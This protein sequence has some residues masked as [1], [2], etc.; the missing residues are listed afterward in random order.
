VF[1]KRYIE[2]E[3]R[4][5]GGT[6][7]VRALSQ[8]VLDEGRLRGEIDR[9]FNEIKRV[10]DLLTEFR[11]SPFDQINQM[12][13]VS[14][15]KVPAEIVELVKL[16]F[17][18]SEATSGKFDIS[19]ATLSNLWKAAIKQKVAPAKDEIL[20][21]KSLVDWRKIELDERE[22]TIYLPHKDMRMSLGGIGKGYA[23]DQAFMLLRDRG[24]E[25]FYLNGAGDIRVHSRN[26]AK[27]SWHIG[28]RNP[29]SEDLSKMIGSL[30]LTNEAVATSGDYIR[31]YDF[32][33]LT[34]HHIIDIQSGNSTNEIVSSTVIANTVLHADVLATSMVLLGVKCGLDMVNSRGLMAFVVDQSGKVHLSKSFVSMM[35]NER[36][37]VQTRSLCE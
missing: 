34:H 11:D 23:V 20:R 15:V 4:L 37:R 2:V 8:R 33:N 5:M 28:I 31:K 19:F 36:Q 14:P 13:G 27:R 16:S 21:V 25:N 12:A 29:L 35:E 22:S 26:D 32:G 30:K 24:V 6:F 10:E 9:A 17:S 18:Y 3:Q 1:N 7:V